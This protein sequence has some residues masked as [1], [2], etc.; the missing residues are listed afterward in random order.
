MARSTPA[1]APQAPLADGVVLVRRRV[2]G[3][4]DALAAA[5]HD[6]ETLR[7]LDDPAMDAEAR[8]TSLSRVEQEWHSG[9]SAPM[10]IA[11][12]ASD[13]AVGTINVQFRSDDE[14]AL[15][16]SVFPEH[17][18]RGFA[19]RA[20]LLVTE[21]VLRDLGL[22]HLFLEADEA[23]AASLRVAEKC[24]FERVGTK[25]EERPGT[26]PR[27]SIVFRRSAA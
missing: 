15:A 10:V 6:P 2:E 19:P 17:R 20:V 16:Y 8:R 25:V 4:L 14:A 18:G 1:P 9:R 5:S 27:V 23:N 3:D 11:E 21:W 26:D 13:L 12:A 24:H 22:P 7:W